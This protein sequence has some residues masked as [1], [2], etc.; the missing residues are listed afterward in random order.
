M[1]G[2]IALIVTVTEFTPSS[3]ILSAYFGSKR[4]LVLIH[5]IKS[6]CSFANFSK[7]S[8]VSS[9]ARE[10]PGP[11][12]PTTAIGLSVVTSLIC[13]I[14]ASGFMTQL[15]TPGLFSSSLISLVQK[16][17]KILHFGATGTCALPTLSCIFSLKHGCA[18]VMCANLEPL[19][20]AIISLPPNI[21]LVS[22]Y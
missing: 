5:L 2:S 1:S 17:Q 18:L 8:N 12:T 16:L 21:T 3:A 6:G 20:S 14:A 11:A 15:A 9:L 13:L 7:N 4:P 22:F 19:C 10:S